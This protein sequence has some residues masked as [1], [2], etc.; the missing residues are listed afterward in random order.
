[1]VVF[2][3]VEGKRFAA[4]YSVSDI[5]SGRADDPQLQSGDV[6]IVA[7]SDLKQGF[8]TVLRLVPLATLVPL[9]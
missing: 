6:I 5:R 3:V 2:R 1:M 4:R 8:N 9:L 7:T